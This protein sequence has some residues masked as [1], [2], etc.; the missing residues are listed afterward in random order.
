HKAMGLLSKDH[1]EGM[2]DGWG[3]A[4]ERI[5]KVAEAKAR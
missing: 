3:H 5:K 4:M 2:P 1:L